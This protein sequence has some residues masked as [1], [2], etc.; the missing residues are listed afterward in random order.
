MG[1]GP[2]PRRSQPQPLPHGPAWHP[3]LLMRGG[4]C[5][6]LRRGAGRRL[7]RPSCQISGKG[8][9]GW[10]GCLA[11]RRGDREGTCMGC[12]RGC[13]VLGGEGGGGMLGRGRGEVHQLPPGQLDLHPIPSAWVLTPTSALAASMEQRAGPPEPRPAGPTTHP[14]PKVSPGLAS[15]NGWD[16]MSPSPAHGA[17]S[18]VWGPWPGLTPLCFVAGRD[19]VGVPRHPLIVGWAGHRYPANATL[20][21][22]AGRG[23]HAAGH[24]HRQPGW[25]GQHG[26]TTR[27]CLEP[28][29]RC[30]L[31]QDP[32]PGHGGPKCG[33]WVG[34]EPLW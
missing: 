22:D 25:G 12:R 14:Q 26:G 23:P 33:T 3:G 8:C 34:W 30:V 21:Q 31:G 10:Q 2:P 9:A 32:Q 5:I 4:S 20:Q 16:H 1:K 6:P 18:L 27:R 29:V 13:R 28:A 7:G 11:E 19:A 15:H 17:L 24:G